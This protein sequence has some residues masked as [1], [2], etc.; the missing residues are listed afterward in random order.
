MS[1]A[2]VRRGPSSINGRTLRIAQA[3]WSS[4]IESGSN[5]ARW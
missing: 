1:S 3:L 4:A 2:G 5:G